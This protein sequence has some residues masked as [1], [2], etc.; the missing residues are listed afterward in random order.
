MDA[1]L[2]VWMMAYI[3][4]LGI[5]L[6]PRNAHGNVGDSVTDACNWAR[7]AADAAVRDFVEVVCQ[8]EVH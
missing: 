5:R 2:Q 8:S 7:V 6:H 3:S 1:R 4:V